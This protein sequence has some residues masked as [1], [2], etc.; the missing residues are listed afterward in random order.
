VVGYGQQFSSELKPSCVGS[1]PPTRGL[2]LGL[3]GRENCRPKNAVSGTPL[4]SITM[5]EILSAQRHL[6]RRSEEVT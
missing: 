2:S 5:Y 1:A 6:K 3:G 4:I